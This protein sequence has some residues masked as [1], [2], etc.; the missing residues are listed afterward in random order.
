MRRYSK[1]ITLLKNSRG[2]HSL[3]TVMGCG[4]GTK[5]NKNGCYDD[6]YAA[7]GAAR[8]GYDFSDYVLREF[9]D[10][11]HIKSI[12]KKINKVDLPFIRVG[13]N[14]DPSEDWNH[15]LSILEKLAGCDK[16]V[17]II[18][19]HWTNISDEYLLRLSDLNIVMNTSISALDDDEVLA[20]A[21][22]QYERLK[23]FCKSM[24]RIVTCDFNTYNPAGFRLALK[25]DELIEI[26]ENYID[27]VFR[28]S[29]TNELVKW[30]VINTTE[31]RFLKNKVLVSKLNKRTY[32]GGCANCKDLCGAKP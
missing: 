19:K 25:Q 13:T 2:V 30:N 20:N 29:K 14:G 23:P 32:F 22:A 8:Y 31:K 5:D 16:Q 7:K 3:D 12:V 6:C 4:S 11:K 18:T 9:K 10:E 28:P 1:N 26:D 27:T 24:L 15:T 17:V 21:L